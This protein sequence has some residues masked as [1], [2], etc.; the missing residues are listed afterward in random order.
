MTDAALRSLLL[1]RVRVIMESLARPV[2]SMSNT[3]QNQADLF[4][5]IDNL[6]LDQRT[7]EPSLKDIERLCGFFSLGKLRNYKKEKGISVSHSNFFVFVRTDSGQYALKFYRPD[8]AKTV[9]MEYALNLLLAEHQ[10]PT[11][12]MLAGVNGKP[13][14]KSNDRLA[15]CYAYIDGPAACQC[16]TRKPLVARKINASLLLLKNILSDTKERFP[17]Q[18]QEVLGQTMKA[19]TR[20]SRALAPYDHKALIDA[21]LL[22]ACRAFQRHQAL[23]TRQGLHN[24]ANLNNFILHQGTLFTLDLSHIQEDYSLSD[25]ASLVISCLFFKVPGKTIKSLI[26]DY[27]SRH[28]IKN[29]LSAV[30]DTLVKTGLIKE[31]LK[32]IEREKSVLKAPCPPKIGRIYKAQLSKRKTMIA[33]LLNEMK[34]T[35]AGY[36]FPVR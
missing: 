16:L 8:S 30:L 27:F 33:S 32:N 35:A 9:A 36:Y 18:K 28:K 2:P 25:L 23:F 1:P 6:L 10:F 14:L 4:A 12:V 24:N 20:N 17:I 7:F 15:A 29:D 26:K 31:Y 21:T 34:E 19:L 3:K 13:F 22:D 11:P 5:G